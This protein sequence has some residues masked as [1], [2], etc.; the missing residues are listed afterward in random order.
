MNITNLTFS[1]HDELIYDDVTIELNDK[2]HIGIIGVNGAGKSTFFK[3]LLKEL[4][5]DY[6]KIKIKP[7]YRISYLPQVITDEVPNTSI[8]V[9]D[10]LM[11]ARPILKIESEMNELYLKMA[12][13]PDNTQINKRLSYLQSQLDYWEYYEAD[14][15]LFRL[16]ESLKIPDN[17]LNQ[18]L[19][20]CSGGQKSK[21]AF[22][23]L[24]YSKPEILLLDE[25]TNHLDL[26][27]KD[28]IIEYLKNYPG[29]VLVIS[30]DQDFLNAVTT[31]TLW[32]DKK[33]KKMELI[34]GNYETYQRKK[35]EREMQLNVE[36]QKEQKQIAKL[37]SIVNLYSNSSGKRKRMAE[38]REKVLNKLLE[39]KIELRPA[40]SHVK[41]QMKLDNIGSTIPLKVEDMSFGYNDELL[42]DNINFE[43]YRGEKFLIVGENGAGKTT[44]LK[45]IS[46]QL[47]PLKGTI[48]ITDKTR[49][50]YY[51]QEHETLDQNKNLLENLKEFGLS[52]GQLRAHLGAFLFN[53]NDVYKKVSFLSPGER[54]R[55]AL[56]KL[57]L[58]KA[59][60]LLLD[61]PTNHLDPETQS[62]IADFFKNYKGTI[63]LVSH[64]P[65]FV[66]KLG[67]ERILLLPEGEVLYY[68]KKI[69][70]FY[71][72]TNNLNKK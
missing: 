48:K 18:K 10:Y 17:L 35:A 62:L 24:L 54:S 25:P 59:N 1:Y 66:D 2:D 70:E 58:T 39:N 19:K 45:L 12:D 36:Y 46:H 15:I 52:E 26:E 7:N 21:I 68:D 49:I 9:F 34:S 29:M 8:T 31:K 50:G 57:T 37:K 69:V 40:D 63:L 44:L 55:L 38:S 71:E 56:A 14:S 67:I 32:I 5:P 20:E 16:I 47:N 33:T 6:G 28:Q 65:S 27:T 22:A 30:H 11:S 51:A 4:T 60:L 42:Y 61:E 64:N 53:G 13:D 72:N 41:L 43:I 23:K 3:L